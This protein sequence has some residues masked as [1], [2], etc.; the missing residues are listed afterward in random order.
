[1][2]EKDAKQ[3]LSQIKEAQNGLLGGLDTS[4]PLPQVSSSTRL[5]SSLNPFAKAPKEVTDFQNAYATQLNKDTVSSLLKGMA[6][7]AGGGAA[8]RGLSGL[9]EATTP[10]K[11]KRT[12]RVVEMPVPY[13]EKGAEAAKQADLDEVTKA[14]RAG[15]RPRSANITRYWDPQHLPWKLTVQSELGANSNPEHNIINLFEQNFVKDP[16]LQHKPTSGF[17][18]TTRWPPVWDDRYKRQDATQSSD[19][20]GQAAASQAESPSVLSRLGRFATSPTG[21]G[22]GLGLGALGTG[23]YLNQRRKPKKEEK[24]ASDSTNTSSW[25][26][27]ATAPVGLPYTIPSALLGFP[28]AFYG[29]WKGVDALMD[30][31]RRAQ[32]ESELDEAK[33]DYESA[34]LGSYKTASDNDGD[35]SA[36]LDKAFSGLQEKAEKAAF[37][38]NAPGSMAGLAAAYTLGTL[39]LGY[40]V[41]DRQMKKNSRKA[42]LDKAL[43][44]RA[45]RAA[46]TQPPELYAIPAPISSEPASV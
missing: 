24:E 9:G 35:V 2:N 11:R 43:R 20:T 38:E 44:E 31:Q 36:N 15:P 18:L 6:I 28:L 30:K 40:Y 8:L 17:L 10:R 46:M 27:G 26:S 14:F 41:V 22:V 1:M 33:R 34:L 39:P 45:R 32:T 12:G 5:M 29:G 16:Y 21:I 4:K 42:I 37:F 13:A 7:L 23:L 19:L 25:F 3:L